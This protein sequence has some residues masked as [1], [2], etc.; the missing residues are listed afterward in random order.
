M[1][2]NAKK[3]SAEVARE[4]KAEAN[5][6]R[7]EKRAKG[8]DESKAKKAPKPKTPKAGTKVGGSFVADGNGGVASVF[9]APA[10]DNGRGIPTKAEAVAAPVEVVPVSVTEPVAVTADVVAEAAKPTAKKPPVPKKKPTPATEAP[11]TTEPTPVSAPTA[12]PLGKS[13]VAT[14]TALAAKGKLTRTQIAEAIGIGSGFTSLLGHLEPAKREPGSLSAR[15]LIAPEAAEVDGK[16]VV[17]WAIT[18]AGKE[19]LKAAK[20]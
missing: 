2:K 4:L 6:V 8:A 10:T 12:K 3:V 20:K 18:D 7:G 14:L 9:D 5:E 11:A 16:K 19:A 17:L 13:A 1:P 15:G